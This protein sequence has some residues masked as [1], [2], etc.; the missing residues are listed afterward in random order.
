MA[1]RIVLICTIVLAAVYFY[2]TSQIP[3]LRTGD[4]LGPKAFPYLLC[5]GL[6]LGAA[7]L[8]GEVMRA[9]KMQ[10]DPDGGSEE[11]QNRGDLLVVGAVVL[12]TVI[13]FGVF[14]MLGYMIATAIYL[15]ILMVFF[16]RSKWL[17]NALT[18][19]LFSLGSY[20]LFSHL[21]GVSLPPG[22]LNY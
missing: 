8:L 17:A 15:F 19:V 13:Y 18:A 10:Q 5:V 6:L 20:L 4:P 14:E 9:Q 1:D 16:N 11:T 2:A 3:S 12:W 7:V 21:L 22:L